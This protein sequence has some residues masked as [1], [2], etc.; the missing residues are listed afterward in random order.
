MRLPQDVMNIIFEYHVE[1]ERVESE[2]NKA[3]QLYFSLAHRCQ[4]VLHDI[5]KLNIANETDRR[6][7]V[8]G[9]NDTQHQ[10]RCIVEEILCEETIKEGDLSLIKILNDQILFELFFL[11]LHPTGHPLV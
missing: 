5:P 11:L 2:I 7:M 4:S 8:A 1:F 3:V 6:I 10:C 9:L